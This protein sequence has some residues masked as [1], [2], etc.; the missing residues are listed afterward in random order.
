MDQR[1]VLSENSVAMKL[2][3]LSY[4]RDRHGNRRVYVRRYGRRIRVREKEGTP[5][6][7]RAVAN[8]LEKLERGPALAVRGHARGTFGWLASAYMGSVE[9]NALDE[10]SQRTRRG[11]IEKCLAHLFKGSPMRECPLSMTTPAKIKAIRDAKADKKGAANKRLKYLSAMFR[12][13][14]EAGVISSNPCRDVRR[15]KYASDG[16][17]TWTVEEVHKFE[18][19]HPIGSKPRLALALLLYLGVR[20]GD[21]VALGPKNIKN[22]VV[23]FIPSKTS[24]KRIELS[25][26]PILPELAKAI[27]AGPIGNDFLLETSH[28]K[29]FSPNGFGNWFKDRCRE[30]GL[31]R[32]SAHGLRKAGATIAAEN[33]ATIHQLMAIFDWATPGQALPYTAGAD[34][35]RLAREAMHMLSMREGET[36]VTS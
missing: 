5:A 28:G 22:N 27:A 2:H 26:K 33:G 36:K 13:G 7:V 29:S 24:Y 8:A 20:R 23:T 6:F 14:I 31:P 18:E 30:A 9:F 35:K 15:F 16:F 21:L 11:V 19:R 17:H 32:C 10:R 3:Y 34:R 25:H 4:E 12:W 1:L